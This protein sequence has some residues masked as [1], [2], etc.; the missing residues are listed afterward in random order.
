MILNAT[1]QSIITFDTETDFF[2][3]VSYRHTPFIEPAHR[4]KT[5]TGG[6]VFSQFSVFNRPFVNPFK[7]HVIAV[8][9]IIKRPVHPT[10][11]RR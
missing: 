4:C 7:R 6:L 10:D 8:I 1:E 5:R 2:L 11:G 9:T 3:Y